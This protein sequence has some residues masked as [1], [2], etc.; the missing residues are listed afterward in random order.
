MPPSQPRPAGIGAGISRQGYR[1]QEYRGRDIEAGI[2]R[3]E[4]W[5]GNIAAGISGQ[6]YRGGDIAV[7]TWSR[8]EGSVSPVPCILW[9]SY[10]LHHGPAR[11][12]SRGSGGSAL[13]SPR[14]GRNAAQP[15]PG[16]S[17]AQPSPAQAPYGAARLGLAESRP[18]RAACPASPADA[19]QK[20]RQEPAGT[21]TRSILP[22][23][24]AGRQRRNSGWGGRGVGSRRRSWE[25]P[26]GAEKTQGLRAAASEAKISDRETKEGDSSLQTLPRVQEAGFTR[27]H[28]MCRTRKCIGIWSK[29]CISFEDVSPLQM[30]LQLR[31]YTAPKKP[32]EP[33]KKT[34]NFPASSLF[35]AVSFI[36]VLKFKDLWLWE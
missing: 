14:P 15:E 1:G 2:A 23:R 22:S 16:F 9:G 21:G 5:G 17:P 30:L 20:R 12:P 29:N 27:K 36:F 4:Y 19:P 13:C 18:P 24:G 34:I 26:P 7:G 31:K 28:L 6:G 10:R 32:Q 33:L 8:P 3:Q 11:M 25:K 35:S